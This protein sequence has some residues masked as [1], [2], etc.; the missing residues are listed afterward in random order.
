MPEGENNLF[1]ELRVTRGLSQAE[2]AAR[3]GVVVRTVRSAE[4]DLAQVSATTIR[5]ILTGLA[6]TSP[7][8][9]EEIS[10]VAEATDWPHSVFWQINEHAEA[11]RDRTRRVKA[12]EAE[13]EIARVLKRFF[14]PTRLAEV[15]VA[16]GR[17]CDSE[18]HD[19]QVELLGSEYLVDMADSV[20]HRHIIEL[21]RAYAENEAAEQYIGV[22]PHTV[23][24]AGVPVTYVDAQGRRMVPMLSDVVPQADGSN[25][26]VHRVVLPPERWE[27]G[28]VVERFEY[29][30]DDGRRLVPTDDL[31]PKPKPKARPLRDGTGG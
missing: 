28:I 16:I 11:I 3:S 26:R 24:G 1:R 9:L 23:G 12:D 6:Y 21:K 29:Y 13:A 4:Q 30:T 10:R 18:R 31:P 22:L 7:L 15:L 5:M 2:L 19:A 27:D 25:V 8:T 14:D 17:L 20:Q